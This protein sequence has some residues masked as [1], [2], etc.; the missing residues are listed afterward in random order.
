MKTFIRLLI[1]ALF[2]SACGHAEIKRIGRHER[3]VKI[4]GPVQ[5]NHMLYYLLL[6]KAKLLECDKIKVIEIVN[7]SHITGLCITQP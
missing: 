6:R 1:I 2:F 4:V 7:E 3:I 5:T